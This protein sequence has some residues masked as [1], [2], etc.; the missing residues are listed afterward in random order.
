MAR[1]A[2]ASLP[3]A[4]P[5]CEAED[6]VAD[7]G[8]V[9]TIRE[10][11]LLD[12]RPQIR[13]AFINKRSGAK[14]GESFL[15]VLAD[16]S[17]GGHVDCAVIN[18]AEEDPADVLVSQMRAWHAL[19]ARRRG[20]KDGDGAEPGGPAESEPLPVILACGG[21]GTF[22]WIASTALKAADAILQSEDRSIVA[23]PDVAPFRYSVIPVPLGTGNDMSGVLGWGRH[24]DCIRSPDSIRRMLGSVAISSFPL[25]SSL[26]A[27]SKG[28]CSR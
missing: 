1:D 13:T 24:L 21:D 26:C 12:C 3:A 16:L 18:L 20:E 10:A 4:P 19:N 7:L 6:D 5:R 8:R 27:A 11:N 28:T 23:S 14:L 2:R 22:S 9:L 15:K 25:S 17:E